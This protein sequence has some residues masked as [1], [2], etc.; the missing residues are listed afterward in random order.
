MKRKSKFRTCQKGL[1]KID[2]QK[3]LITKGKSFEMKNF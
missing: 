1:F 3:R 2:K